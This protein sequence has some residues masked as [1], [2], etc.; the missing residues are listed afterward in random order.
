MSWNNANKNLADY[1]RQLTERSELAETPKTQLDTLP[2]TNEVKESLRYKAIVKFSNAV[3]LTGEDWINFKKQFE[4]VYEGFFMK[5]RDT[6]PG[7]STG[8][9]RLAALLK[10]RLS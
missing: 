1:T 2:E 8:D 3:I 5:L 9:T 10:L 6:Y 4:N 7:L